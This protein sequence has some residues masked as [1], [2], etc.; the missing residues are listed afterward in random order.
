MLLQGGSVHGIENATFAAGLTNYNNWVQSSPDIVYK[1]D[2]GNFLTF[3]TLDPGVTATYWDEAA[4]DQ[5]HPTSAPSGAAM[6]T[7]VVNVLTTNSLP[8]QPV[9][10]R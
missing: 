4:G 3:A 2:D 8:F 9:G 6:G 7:N 1:V 10:F 5:K